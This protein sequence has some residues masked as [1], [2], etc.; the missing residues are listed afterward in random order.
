MYLTI[1]DRKSGIFDSLLLP[2]VQPNLV[3]VLV[4]G[5]VLV[6]TVV[7]VVAVVVVAVLHRRW[8]CVPARW[9]VPCRTVTVLTL[10][11]VRRYRAR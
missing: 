3:L 9:Y 8:V 5:L 2:P 7:V 6:V 11:Q 1:Y 4:L 10:R